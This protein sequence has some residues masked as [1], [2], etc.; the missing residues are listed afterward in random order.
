MDPHKRYANKHYDDKVE[1]IMME[2]KKDNIYWNN[3]GHVIL[4][5]VSTSKTV[6]PGCVDNKHI[7]YIIEPGEGIDV[8]CFS[9]SPFKENK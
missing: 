1:E 2:E 9:L 7:K 6:Y 4:M 5:S 8:S 3:S